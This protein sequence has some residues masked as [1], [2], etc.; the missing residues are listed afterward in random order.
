MISIVIPTLNEE[1]TIRGMLDSL[2]SKLTLPHEII[3][4]DGH[5]SDRTVEI[6]LGLADQVV[7]HS[8]QFRQNIAQGRNAG[9]RAAR[10]EF[11]V[12]LDA[13]S[14]I[15]DPDAFFTHALAKFSVD[16]KLVGLTAK[17]KVLPQYETRAD[18]MVL[19]VLNFNVYVLNNIIHRGEATGEFQMI[20]KSAFD[21]LG[22]YRED[23]ITREDA[24][25]FLRLSRIGRTMQDRDI[26][27]FHSG[28]R[29]HKIG[30]PRLLS[31]WAVNSLWVA[32]FDK[33]RHKEWTVVR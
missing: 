32:L 25:M 14:R 28:R 10:G 22:G 8:G 21:A 27:A 12:F 7:E 33:A 31:Q 19:G 6:A 18:K 2:K 15:K 13:D 4:S 17:L 16:P 20:R 1:G 3:V 5:S 9:A 24:D 30:W 11:L 29:A 23:L 26:T